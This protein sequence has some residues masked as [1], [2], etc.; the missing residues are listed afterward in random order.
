MA[1]GNE[2]TRTTISDVVRVWGKYQLSLHWGHQR[3]LSIVYIWNHS[4]IAY[5]NILS[6]TISSFIWSGHCH[7]STVCTADLSC[8]LSA[9][10]SHMT[11]VHHCMHHWEWHWHTWTCSY[12]NRTDKI[13]CTCMTDDP[14]THEL[15]V[16]LH[17][18]M[19]LES[20]YCYRAH[21]KHESDHD[22]TLLSFASTSWRA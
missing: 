3:L 18:F 13:T 9:H 16:S 19:C 12:V 1:C 6:G 8:L 2:C 15:V 5:W 4:S 20:L 21:L 7:T 14:S 10:I 11:M 17:R 22:K